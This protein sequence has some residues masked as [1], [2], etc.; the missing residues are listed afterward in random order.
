MRIAAVYGRGVL[1]ARDCRKSAKSRAGPVNKCDPGGVGR[2]HA[3]LFTHSEGNEHVEKPI[4][5][6]TRDRAR[7]AVA[8]LEVGCGTGPDLV[9]AA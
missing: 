5:V 4:G 1:M 3:L 9:F 7:D 6:L 2:A 8:I